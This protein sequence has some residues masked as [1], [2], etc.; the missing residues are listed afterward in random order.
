MLLS[1]LRKLSKIV[2]VYLLFANSAHAGVLD[3][4]LQ[5]NQ[6]F[7]VQWNISGGNLNA[8]GFNYIYSSVNYATQSTSAS[9]WTAA[10][11]ADA[12]ANGRY[13]AFFNSTT[14]PGT[15]GMAVYNSDG[16]VYKIIN[17]TGSFRALAS[18]AIFYN[19]NGMWGTLITTEAGYNLGGSGSWAI[20]KDYP[21]SADLAAYQA[22]AYSGGKPAPPPAPTPVYGS[23]GLTTAQQIRMD[24]MLADANAG[25]GN[26][27]EANIMGD[28]NDVYIDQAGAPSYI[29]LMILGNNNSFNSTQSMDIGAHAYNETEILGDNNNVNLIQTGSGMKAAFINVTGNSN[30]ASVTQKDSGEHYVQLD[31]TGDS[32]SA[33]ILQEGSGNHEATV[34]LDGTQPWNFN[35]TQGGTNDQTFTLPHDMSDGSNVSGSCNAIGGCNLTVTQ[36]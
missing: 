26:T 20:T 3:L 32:H 29:N 8:S 35:L 15:Y 16:S 4:R 24:A 36:Q 34:S 25:Q 21:T 12:G 28:S 18:G 6:I 22:P 9:R 23:S 2:F 30:T 11:T 5:V 31:I 27:V 1:I 19:G 10:Q 14:N 33:T 17:N 7:D 13:I